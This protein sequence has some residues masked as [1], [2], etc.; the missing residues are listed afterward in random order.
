M[1]SAGPLTW[2]RR[3]ST[4]ARV[5]A[6]VS[7]SRTGSDRWTCLS[8]MVSALAAGSRAG[9][10]FRASA[11]KRASP[12]PSIVPVRPKKSSRRPLLRIMRT[13]CTIAAQAS[14]PIA[15]SGVPCQWPQKNLFQFRHAA[16]V[17]SVFH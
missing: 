6:L 3:T 16:S 14:P 4:P 13:R 1:R 9:R 11:S 2:L 8:S 15:P 10:A 7:W 5:P 17:V 12:S